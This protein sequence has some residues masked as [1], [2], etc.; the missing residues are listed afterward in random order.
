M[1]LT[2]GCIESN[3]DTTVYRE[4]NPDNVFFFSA[5]STK[6]KRAKGAS[7]RLTIGSSS[8][9]RCDSLERGA[10]RVFFVVVV[11]VAGNGIRFL[12]FSSLL[13]VFL[14]FSDVFVVVVVVVVVICVLFRRGV[15]EDA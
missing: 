11:V 14:L 2:Y 5:P 9:V 10:S 3:S 15:Q 13:Y 6:R 12:F 7:V 4:K 1:K 8:S